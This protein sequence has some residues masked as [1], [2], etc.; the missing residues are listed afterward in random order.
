MATAT[1]AEPQATTAATRR[2]SRE[3]WIRQGKEQ[4]G[5]RI[6]LIVLCGYYLLPF[7]WMFVSALKP[8]D[9]LTAY[10]PTWYPHTFEWSNFSRAIDVFPFWTYL[11]NSLIITGFSV[12]GVALSVPLVAYGFS[13][14]DWPGRD[15]VFYLV[16]ATVFIPYPV[17]IIALFDI[18]A[19]LNWV[20]T[21]YPLIVPFFFCFI[22]APFWI[23]LMRQFLLQIP[24]D[25]SDAAKIDGA[26]E[27][28]IMLQI[29]MPQAWPALCAVALF[30]ALER[31]NDFLGPLLYL[32]DPDKYTLSIGLQFFQSQTRYDIQFNLLMAASTLVI[33]PV[34]ILFFAFQRFFVE[35]VTVTSIK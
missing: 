14:I 33:I 4:V 22:P 5:T 27:L 17:L 30:A 24:A 28:R 35:G 29:I 6:L 15:K 26:S 1:I 20:N 18:F 21:F 9:E 3:R 11:Q 32:Q 31:W 13:R 34:L 2:K 25:L 19:R 10:P 8:T 7:Y 12:L 16:L 23:F